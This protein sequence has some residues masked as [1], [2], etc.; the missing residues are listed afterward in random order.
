GATTTSLGGCE[1]DAALGFYRD[2]LRALL[3]SGVPFLVGGGFAFSYYTGVR[4]RTKDLDLF[5]R[6]E[7][8]TRT[9]A[10][11]AAAGHRA[12]T[13]APHWLGKVWGGDLFVD[14]VWSSGNGV[15]VVDDEWFRYAEPAVMLDLAAWLCPVEEM[16]WSKAYVLERERYDG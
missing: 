2:V 5:V 14:L 4:R 7:D 11:I 6:P 13:V 12:E 15:A 8:A 1:E 9:L 3:A 16:I 10:A